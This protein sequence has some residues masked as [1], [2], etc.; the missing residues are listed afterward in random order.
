M[1][2]VILISRVLFGQTQPRATPASAWF[3][4]NAFPA[5]KSAGDGWASAR[6]CGNKTAGEVGFSGI[7]QGMSAVD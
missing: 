6:R 5:T 7:V 4:P 3:I 2:T 1:P